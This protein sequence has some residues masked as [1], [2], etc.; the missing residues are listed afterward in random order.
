MTSTV[1]ASK[2][3]L[4]AS[5]SVSALLLRDLADVLAVLQQLLAVDRTTPADTAP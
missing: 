2:T 4:E 5:R 3:A 1:F